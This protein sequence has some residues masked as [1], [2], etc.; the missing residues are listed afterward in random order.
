MT[1]TNE[2]PT[3][4]GMDSEQFTQL[5]VAKQSVAGLLADPNEQDALLNATDAWLASLGPYM[6]EQFVTQTSAE[7]PLGERIR[8]FT[9]T[10]GAI[11]VVTPAQEAAAILA[12]S[13]AAVDLKAETPAPEVPAAETPVAD[14]AVVGT[15]TPAP[16]ETT[17]VLPPLPF[18][19]NAVHPIDAH[20]KNTTVTITSAP[21][22]NILGG[23]A[24]DHG[25]GRKSDGNTIHAGDPLTHLPVGSQIIVGEDGPTKLAVKVVAPDGTPHIGLGAN[26]HAAIA[27]LW[28]MLVKFGHAV[29]ADVEQVV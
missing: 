9:S 28:A 5:V 21:N 24:V 6:L 16:I 20:S 18:D 11:K 8:A 17:T 22:G 3:P 29:V 2:V 12:V 23:Y 13:N 10:L 25:N 14:P 19:A 26:L 27:S 7:T 1:T 15:I 4:D